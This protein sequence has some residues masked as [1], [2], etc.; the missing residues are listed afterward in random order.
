MRAHTKS[1][2]LSILARFCVC[3]LPLCALAVLL[4]TGGAQTFAQTLERSLT[5]A[6]APAVAEVLQYPELPAGCEAASLASALSAYGYNASA[7]EIVDQYMSRDGTWSDPASYFGVPR[8]G[9]GAF[10]PAVAEAANRYLSAHR[11]SEQAR[12]VSGLAFADLANLAQNGT[13]VVIWTTLSG[14]DPVFADFSIGDYPWYPN[15]HCIVFY[16][17]TGDAALVMDPRIGYTTRTLSS[18][19]ESYCACGSYAVIIDKT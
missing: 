2:A 6:K 9:G 8:S 15:E 17:I 11:A 4:F 10:P 7:S 14:E 3:T 16:G 12:D 13:P 18:L 5:A 19:A 1:T